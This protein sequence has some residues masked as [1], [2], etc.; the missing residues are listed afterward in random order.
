MKRP[1]A[2]LYMMNK[3]LYKR[4][5]YLA[6]MA[7]IF[8][9]VCIFTAVSK[10]DKGFLHIALTQKGDEVCGM[11]QSLLEEDSMIR[12]T[13]IDDPE[14]GIR[15]VRNG[16]AD[17]LW[18][19]SEELKDHS[20]EK[21]N[22]PTVTVVEREQTVFLRLAREKLH[23][24][25][26]SY[27]ARAVFLDYSRENLPMLN[28]LSDEQLLSYFENTKIDDELFV[29]DNPVSQSVQNGSASYL[30]AP[31]RGLLAVLCVL[32]AMAGALY[33][34]QD[35]ERKLFS[36]LPLRYRPIL[37][38]LCVWVSALNIAVVALLSLWASGLYELTLREILNTVLFSLCTT[39]FAV[40]LQEICCKIGVY[41][42][43]IPALITAMSFLCP[44]FFNLRS[45]RAVSLFFPPTY[46]IYGS[47]HGK[48]LLYMCAYTL[49]CLLLA[50]FL[51]LLKGKKEESQ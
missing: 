16:Q 7:L 31:L 6:L 1:F 28:G 24:L 38:F 26:F 18:I 33:H 45:A 44:V 34:L 37:S 9:S 36:N 11:V 27:N 39:A 3:R 17:A 40:L 5:T 8:A 13:Y 47:Y 49:S 41:A 15:A 10:K 50:Y 35:E 20:Y 29:F 48:Y 12:F 19:F 14:D 32:G 21:L 25:L 4:G 42:A 22:F 2:W 43:M 46:Y 30:T 51:R 23:S